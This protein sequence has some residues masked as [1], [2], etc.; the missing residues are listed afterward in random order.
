M[1]L[2]KSFDKSTIEK[3]ILD[4]GPTTFAEL[5][6]ILGPAA[7]GSVTLTDS[8]DEN[9]VFCVGLSRRAAQA[10]HDLIQE[11]RIELV[12][13]HPLVCIKDGWIGCIPRLP[14]ANEHPACGS[15]N[16][17]WMPAIMTPPQRP[18]IDSSPA[19]QAAA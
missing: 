15:R 11:G 7:R 19:Y 3:I 17:R 13:A 18:R 14:I 16:E 10:I 9:L 2:A 4:N 5:I 1:I 8:R 6:E 12:P